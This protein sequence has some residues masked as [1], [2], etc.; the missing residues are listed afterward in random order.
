MYRLYKLNRLEFR[1]KFKNHPKIEAYLDSVKKQ[2]EAQI[3]GDS[4]TLLELLKKPMARGG[5]SPK[6]EEIIRSVPTASHKKFMSES[7]EYLES[8]FKFARWTKSFA[9]NRP[10]N[11]ATNRIIEAMKQI[12]DEN[13]DKRLKLRYIIKAI[14]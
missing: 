12:S 8:A 3:T 14:E 7:K 1:E 6:D 5:W 13:S 11:D 4:S 10:F 9:G 2:Y